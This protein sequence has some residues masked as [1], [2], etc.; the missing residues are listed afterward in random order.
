MKPVPQS[1][2]PLCSREAVAAM[3]IAARLLGAGR[4]RAG[5]DPSA[6]RLAGRARCWSPSVAW[7]QRRHGARAQ[8]TVHCRTG[9]RSA[10]SSP[11]PIS[12]RRS[13]RL[14]RRMAAVSRRGRGHRC[15]QQLPRLVH[16]AAQGPAG[17]DRR[18]GL[19]A[20]S[21]HRH[22]ADGRC[23]RRRRAP[24]RLHAISARHPG[25]GRGRRGRAPVGR[26]LR[27]RAGGY[28]RGF[29]Q[30]TGRL[31][32]PRWPSRSVAARS[33]TCCASPRPISSAP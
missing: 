31:S 3:D 30:S 18:L 25:F 24:R 32:A 23:L 19:G 28:G 12:S 1:P 16:L 17:H 5:I 29:R 13:S 10:V 6:R 2:A 11:A 26:H 8:R 27:R 14:L 9:A 4:R 22:G 7:Q 33:A 20:G 21:G 15:G